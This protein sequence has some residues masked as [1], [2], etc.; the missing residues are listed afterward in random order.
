MQILQLTS[1]NKVERRLHHPSSDHERS[2]DA[3]AITASRR[4]VALSCLAHR[5]PSLDFLHPNPKQY[6]AQAYKLHVLPTAR[7]TSR[8]FAAITQWHTLCSSTG[9]YSD[10]EDSKLWKQ[11]RSCVVAVFHRTRCGSRGRSL[12]YTR[13]VWRYRNMTC[14]SWW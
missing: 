1:S 4:T 13:P 2:I 3:S 10:A 14:V 5:A 7:T 9:L 11:R 6:V 8:P 12:A